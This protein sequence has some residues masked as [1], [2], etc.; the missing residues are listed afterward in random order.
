MY[1]RESS[2]GVL[3]VSIHLNIYADNP[4][5]ESLLAFMRSRYP[6]ADEG[7]K[8]V[9]MNSAIKWLRTADEFKYLV[10]LD[11]GDEVSLDFA[12]I[13]PAACLHSDKP[14]ESPVPS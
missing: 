13:D 8:I 3:P 7:E 9:I 5:V 6:D 12:R 11:A 4:E 2:H 14:A 1:P 10:N